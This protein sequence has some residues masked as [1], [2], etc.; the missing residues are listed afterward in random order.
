MYVFLEDCL[1]E[2]N[3]SDGFMK[4]YVPNCQYDT[5]FADLLNKLIKDTVKAMCTY[6]DF[7]CSIS[8]TLWH[9][10]LNIIEII[11]TH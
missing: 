2:I 11:L 9:Y 3:Y 6:D 1:I 4:I 5:N 7:K 10:N 8:N